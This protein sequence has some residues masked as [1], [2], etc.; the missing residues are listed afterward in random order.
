MLEPLIAIAGSA[1]SQ[2]TYDPPMPDAVKTQQVAENLGQALAEAGCRLLVYSPDYIERHVVRGFVAKAK[3]NE[4]IQVR[5]PPDQATKLFAEE[6]ADKPFNRQ[7]DRNKHWEATYYRSLRDAHG[8]ILVGGGRSTLITGFLALGYRIP[9]L[10]LASFGG[11]A[12]QVWEAISPGQDL[13]SSEDSNLMMK[14]WAPG[15]AKDWVESLLAQ[16]QRRATEEKGLKHALYRP[17]ILSLVLLTAALL[18]VTISL[19]GLAD[20]KV[21]FLILLVCSALSGACGAI[22][23]SLSALVGVVQE[24]LER[25]PPLTLTLAFG[26]IAGVIALALALL[27]QLVANPELLDVVPKNTTNALMLL[28]SL[29]IGFVAGLTFDAVIRKLWVTDVVQ[30]SAIALQKP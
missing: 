8:I 15:L 11:A 23:R 27:P 7:I 1:D 18:C 28:Q 2:R 25:Y 3:N 19:L 21:Y 4:L 24:R 20:R 29:I 10:A 22:I 13:P 30:T 5:C 26:M 14:P 6:Q 9:L 12:Q 17:A 16:R